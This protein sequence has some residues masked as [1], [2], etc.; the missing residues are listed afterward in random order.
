MYQSQ[1]RLFTASFAAILLIA[2]AAAEL[3]AAEKAPKI[4]PDPAI[5]KKIQEVTKA[6][7]NASA[8]EE[9]GE[10]NVF[11]AMQELQIAARNHRK[12]A[13]Q[14]I[15]H[16]AAS[17]KTAGT[18]TMPR[19]VQDLDISSITLAKAALLWIDGDRNRIDSTTIRIFD[20]VEDKRGDN[21][22]F[23]AYLDSIN[24]SVRTNDTLP[25]VFIARMLEQ[26][27]QQA[28]EE[29][30]LVFFKRDLDRAKPIL[31][32][33]HVI[34]EHLW[35]RR[36]EFVGPKADPAVAKAL[37][38]L[39]EN[40]HWWVRLYVAETII[41]HPDLSTPEIQKRIAKDKNAAFTQPARRESERE[42][43]NNAEAEAVRKRAEA[44]AEADRAKQ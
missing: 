23:S 20:L 8:G 2:T 30:T 11:R 32:N 7:L 3:D 44:D 13:E 34:G 14:L 39:A 29:L 16:H 15:L 38:E 35:K 27:P 6:L 33:S 28:I 21:Y 36:F 9:D 17:T 40:E 19:V 18:M 31:W 22:D 1:W 37:A 24:E 25:E 26:S 4:V 42:A 12:L 10:A 41:A 5:Q 43:A